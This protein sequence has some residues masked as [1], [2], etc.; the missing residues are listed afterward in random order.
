VRLGED[1][2]GLVLRPAG[3]TDPAPPVL[4]P[5]DPSV[6]VWRDNT[7]EVCAYAYSVGGR[8]CMDWPALARFCFD[9]P[10]DTVLAWAAP[11]VA[12]HAI[13]RVHRRGVVPAALQR[14]GFETLHASAVRLPAGVVG[15]LGQAGAGKST[16]ARAFAAVAGADPWAD[17]T[18]VL[19]VE[20]DE[21]AAVPIPFDVGLRPSSARHFGEEPSGVITASGGPAPLAALMMLERGSAS[22][23][24]TPLDARDAFESVL[25]HACT[26]SMTD[27]VRRRQM[28]QHYLTL[29]ARVPV[30][31]LAYPTDFGALPAV[32]DV[33]AGT[34]SRTGV[35]R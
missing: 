6:D 3:P 19:A 30:F 35:G 32:V 24:A 16:L 25:P 23:L 33:V 12:A 21:T 13:E 7:G 34:V 4:R 11:G 17:D 5:P 27:A 29:A 15:F 9:E 10:G 8:H 14:L 18:L 22:I 31:R 20:D 1:R 28:V 26:F 2:P